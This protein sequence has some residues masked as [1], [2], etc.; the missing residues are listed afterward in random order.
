MAL[1]LRMGVFTLRFSD[2]FPMVD[3]NYV[4]P[5]SSI[6]PQ[7][8]IE[9][10]ERPFSDYGVY[11][12]QGSDAEILKSPAAKKN[13]LQNIK[14][15]IGA[16][17]DGEFVFFQTKEVKL[18][19]LLRAYTLTEFWRNYNALLYDLSRPGERLLYMDST[20][21]EYPCFYKGCTV[22]KFS[23][24]GKIWFQFTLALVFTSYRVEGEDS[25]LASED[26]KLIIT[27]EDDNVINLLS[28]AN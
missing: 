24:V 17:Y 8:G 10:D 13:L 21:D 18:N 20:G 16:I 25:I 11:V 2:D 6:V 22:S 4:S 14:S 12:L 15:Q 19:C 9:L 27:E 5:Q 3:Y 1:A 7:R 26:D 28:Y 23:P